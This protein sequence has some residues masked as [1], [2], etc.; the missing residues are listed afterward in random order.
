ML[1][2]IIFKGIENTDSQG[3]EAMLNQI[4]MVTNYWITFICIPYMFM[5]KDKPILPPS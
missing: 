5:I 2:G 1:S 4:I 3:V